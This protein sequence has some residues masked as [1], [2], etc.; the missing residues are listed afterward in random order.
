MHP[1]RPC[2]RTGSFHLRA[3]QVL[4]YRP[5]GNMDNRTAIERFNS[6]IRVDESGCVVWTAGKSKSGYGKFTCDGCWRAHRWIFQYVNGQ[7]PDG[8]QIDHLCNRRD[9]VNPD[10]LRAV[11]ARENSLAAHSN[12]IARNNLTKNSCPRGHILAAWNVNDSSRV[13]GE[14]ACKACNLARSRNRHRGRPAGW[15]MGEAD[16]L[17]EEFKAAA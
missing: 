16:R 2:S 4:A 11:T 10:H 13:R 14:R 6:K 3:S 5:G 7:I 12:A 17:Y 1:P 9:C 8:L 15:W